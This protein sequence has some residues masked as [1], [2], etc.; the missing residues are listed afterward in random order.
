MDMK[1]TMRREETIK[2]KCTK[3][4]KAIIESKAKDKGIS[5]SQ[6]CRNAALDNMNNRTTYPLS[7]YTALAKH[8]DVVKVLHELSEKRIEKCDDQWYRLFNAQINLLDELERM[9]WLG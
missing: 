2:I 6:Y 4:E 5:A 9:L 8:Q 1:E 7:Y 3:E